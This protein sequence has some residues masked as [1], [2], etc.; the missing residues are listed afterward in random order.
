MDDPES[1]TWVNIFNG[2][3]LFIIP[4]KTHLLYLLLLTFSTALIW[5]SMVSRMKERATWS[6]SSSSGLIAFSNRINLSSFCFT[7]KNNYN[8]LKTM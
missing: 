2:Q 1:L 4:Y 8:H 7:Y 6:L 3:T 5:V